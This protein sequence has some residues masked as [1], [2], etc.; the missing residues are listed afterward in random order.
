MGRHVRPAQL[1]CK[2]LSGAPA[3]LAQLLLA[4]L[5]FASLVYKRCSSQLCSV[6]FSHINCLRYPLEFLRTLTGTFWTRGPPAVAV[7][8]SVAAGNHAKAHQ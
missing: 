7:D 1:Q 2:L 4:V 3:L 5:A 8:A 6:I